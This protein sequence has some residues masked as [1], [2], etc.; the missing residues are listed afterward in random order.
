[1]QP[2][3]QMERLRLQPGARAAAAESSGSPDVQA[4]KRV[5]AAVLSASPGSVVPQLAEPQVAQVLA[6]AGAPAA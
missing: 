3:V 4:V 1:M 2:R 6:V 5:T